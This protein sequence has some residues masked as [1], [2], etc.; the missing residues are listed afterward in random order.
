MVNSPGAFSLTY[1]GADGVAGTADDMP[2]TLSWDEYL[3][4]GNEVTLT[5]GGPI[6][7]VGDYQFS[8]N[9]SVVSNP[10]GTA[11]DGNGDG[12]GGDSWVR[13]FHANDGDTLGDSYC[14]A[15]PNSTGL[16]APIRA[17][18]SDV[19]V[20]NDLT[21]T[22]R[23][24]PAGVPGL[25]FVGTDA[26]QVPFGDGFRC[27]GG[28]TVIR[29]QPPVAATAQGVATRSL[30]LA[31]PPLAGFVVGGADLNFQF[32]YRDNAAGM[33]GFNLSDGVNILFQ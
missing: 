16:I 15:A 25:Y 29:I 30:D 7:Q 33:S 4:A 5:V 14:I 24:L 18:G 3:I 11:L 6:D 28:S 31:S 17:A 12:T 23:N 1:L 19:V 21:L 8:A 9:A 22:T 27:V 10:F 13:N 2:V 26:I 20:F 32:W